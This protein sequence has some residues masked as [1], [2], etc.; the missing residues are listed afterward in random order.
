MDRKQVKCS[1]GETD[2]DNF[3]A[4]YK[5]VCKACIRIRK[6]KWEAA[7]K[8]KLKSKR[9]VWEQNNK[10]NIKEYQKLYYKINKSLIRENRKIYVKNVLRSN[11]KY[12]CIQNIRNRHRKVLLAKLNTTKYL[13]C[14]SSELKIYIESKF[15]SWMNW[16]NYGYGKG[17]WVIDHIIPI[18]TYKK[19]NDNKFDY[20][21][22]YNKKLLHFTNLQPLSFEDNLIK[23]DKLF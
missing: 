1:C 14:N 20:N 17:K 12:K 19:D 3:Y 15:Q 2:K 11:N 6:R 7:N 13:G 5:G 9:N 21:S 4:R 8:E 16:D 23:R 18:S 22:E 10:D